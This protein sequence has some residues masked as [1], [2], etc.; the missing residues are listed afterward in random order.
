MREGADSVARAPRWGVRPIAPSARCCDAG[1]MTQVAEQRTLD[2]SRFDQIESGQH[3]ALEGRRSADRRAVAGRPHSAPVRLP[4][5]QRYALRDPIA[6]A[7]D[8]PEG[9]IG[10]VTGMR[11]APFEYWPDE[12]IVEVPDGHRL[13]VPVSTVSA[14]L[15]REGRL[16]LK[17]APAGARPVP[18]PQKSLLTR[19]LTWR[20]AA[21]AS[22]ILG[23]GAYVATFVALALDTGLDWAPGLAASGAAAGAAA[24]VSGRKAGPSRLAA[25]GLG[26]FW[27]PLAA[28]AILSVVLIFR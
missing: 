14:V 21:I 22:A 6:Y 25:A 18:R 19:A 4:F 13:R 20:L 26:S 3:A 2:R 15:P 28:G 12:L 17:R 27:L 23:L 1:S 8:A 11:I 10:F 9:E 5:R 24:A 16:L 7:V